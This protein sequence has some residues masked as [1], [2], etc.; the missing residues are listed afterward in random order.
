MPK[1]F[2]VE[3]CHAIQRE[4][5]CHFDN[6]FVFAFM[7]RVLKTVANFTSNIS[8]FFNS[9]ANSHLVLKVTDQTHAGNVKFHDETVLS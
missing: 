7:N 1:Q 2:F 8:K 6:L 4:V 3:I 5:D 9:L